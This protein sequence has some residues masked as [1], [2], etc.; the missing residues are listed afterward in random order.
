MHNAEPKRGHPVEGQM[1]FG[2]R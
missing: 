2:K 1:G